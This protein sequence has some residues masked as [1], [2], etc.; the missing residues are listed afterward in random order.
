MSREYTL[1]YTVELTVIINN[2]DFK[3]ILA[4]QQAGLHTATEEH[5]R[6]KA[7]IVEGSVPK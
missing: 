4:Q 1:Y 3:A 2:N 5:A 6:L 7:K